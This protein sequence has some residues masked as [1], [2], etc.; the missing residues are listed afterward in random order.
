MLMLGFSGMPGAFAQDPEVEASKDSSE[1]VEQ[2]E[3]SYRR[4]MELEDARSRDRTYIDNTYTRSAKSERLD[5]LPQESRDNIRD[6]LIDVIVENGD[7]EP[8]DALAEYPYQP[9]TAAE[10]DA[11][12]MQLEQDAWEEQIEKYHT[13]EATAFGAYRGPVPGP[14]NPGGQEGGEEGDGSEGQPGGGKGGKDDGG[15]EDD[16]SAAATYQP[17]QA[18]SAKPENE[19]STAGVS[20]S[21][22]SFLRGGSA[23]ADPSAQELPS[24]TATESQSQAQEDSQSQ[25]ASEQASAE[26]LAQEQSEQ[27][28]APKEATPD[29][30]GII[31][32][33]DL[34]KLEGMEPVTEMEENE[35]L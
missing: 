9:T 4:Q 33:E 27:Q 26:Q 25:Q 30:R 17:Y 8:G 5:K 10:A 35:D 19:V 13:R 7:W 11:A 2:R 24:L 14:G 6:Q 32:I 28:D 20:E 29:L 18:S 16:S 31:A 1:Q 22:L 23:Q 3:D 12:L 15:E 21:A 34:D